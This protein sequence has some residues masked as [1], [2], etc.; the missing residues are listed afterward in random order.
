M[1]EKEYYVSRCHHCG[2]EIFFVLEGDLYK[3]VAK[4]KCPHCGRDNVIYLME[5]R[6]IIDKEK[7]KEIEQSGKFQKEVKQEIQKKE[8]IEEDFPQTLDLRP[9]TIKPTIASILLVGIFLMNIS[10]IGTIVYGNEVTVKDM[11]P[12]SINEKFMETVKIEIDKNKLEWR[13][14]WGLNSLEIGG[15]NLKIFLLPFL[16]DF[17][18]VRATVTPAKNIDSSSYDLNSIIEENA[19]YVDIKPMVDNK[20]KLV[21]RDIGK[22]IEK[23]NILDIHPDNGTYNFKIIMEIKNGTHHKDAII[24]AEGKKFA[25]SSISQIKI[26]NDSKSWQSFKGEYGDYTLQNLTISTDKKTHINTLRINNVVYSPSQTPFGKVSLESFNIKGYTL[27]TFIILL[28]FVIISLFIL[29]SAI[30][31]EKRKK[32]FSVIFAC[33]LGILCIGIYLFSMILG[34]IALALVI[35]ARDEFD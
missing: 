27:F 17:E 13:G 11:I 25:L 16:K 7:I 15:N 33:I 1:A 34:I 26:D 28:L 31:C 6:Q 2:K 3:K 29:Y 14:Y 19:I 5:A 35:S 10:I 8:E 30:N 24:E 23:L 9:R 22:K 4:I 21:I 18:G 32:L 12:V 20:N